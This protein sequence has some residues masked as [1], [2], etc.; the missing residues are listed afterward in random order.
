[1]SPSASR[2]RALGYRLVGPAFDYV[3][4]LR[5][6]EWPIIAA[7]V[8]VGLVLAVGFSGLRLLPLGTTLLGMVLWVVCL[9][10]GTL[11]INSAF[12]QDTG[13]IAYLRHPPPPPRYLFGFGAALMSFGLGASWALPP[14]FRWAYGLCLLLSFLYS[15]PP[16][17]LKAVAGL[18]W[19]IN[20][21]GFGALTAYA[22]WAI[23]GVAVGET[24]R[25]VLLAFCPLFAALY[26]LTQLYQLDEDCAR[27]D[28]TLAVVLGVRG[29]LIVALISMF[30]AFGMFAAA[31]LESGWPLSWPGSMRW[32]VLALALLSWLG[33][34]LPWLRHG[35]RLAPA[36][37]Q[38]RMYLALAAWA[39]TD[40]AVLLGFGR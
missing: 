1:M 4:H 29:S 5:P 16:V 7:H 23:T 37:H 22:G 33:V 35:G 10:G 28:R 12:D 18:D 40:A 3:L 14:G 27:G 32:I 15:V 24:G 34:L 13:D 31:G 25:T 38:G 8:G 30:L 21:W 26:P 2:P 6:A 39:V 9:N 36:E 11:A 17:R 19:L 20:M